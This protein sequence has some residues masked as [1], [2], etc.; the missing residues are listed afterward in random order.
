MLPKESKI[1][2]KNSW[3]LVSLGWWY[4]FSVNADRQFAG[5]LTTDRCDSIEI[6]KTVS[7]VLIES[8]PCRICQG[9]LVPS[10]LKYKFWLASFES[11]RGGG[12]K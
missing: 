3:K 12:A 8:Y 1:F 2:S 11:P 4:I 5:N 7:S 10:E 6:F 9:I